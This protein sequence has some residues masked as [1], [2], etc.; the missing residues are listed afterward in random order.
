[1][2]AA[3][4]KIDRTIKKEPKYINEPKYVLLAFG[5]RPSSRSGSR[6]TATSL[7]IDRNGN[8]DLTEDGERLRTAS[9]RWTAKVGDS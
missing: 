5:P 3:S 6:S 7:Y 9:F 2:P 8:G 4:P 1:M